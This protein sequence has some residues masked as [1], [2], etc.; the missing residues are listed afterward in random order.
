MKKKIV[1]QQ[2]LDSL[3]QIMKIST[4]ENNPKIQKYKDPRVWVDK[5]G[6][7]VTE[8]LGLKVKKKVLVP[9][10]KS[11]ILTLLKENYHD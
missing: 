4:K 2:I 8:S 7:I 1:K 11:K 5:S 3:K 10:S 6:K 9:D